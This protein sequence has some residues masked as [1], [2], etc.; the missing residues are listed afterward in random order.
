VVNEWLLDAH[1]LVLLREAVRTVDML[2]ELDAVVRRD[3]P[4]VDGQRGK[5][6]HPALVEARQ[7]KFALARLFAAL[8][9]PDGV[10]GDESRGRRQ[11]RVGARGTYK[12]GRQGLRPRTSG[13]TGRAHR[14]AGCP[15]VPDRAGVRGRL[16]PA[17][18]PAD[19]AP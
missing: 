2:D 12:V 17:H 11:R 14:S 1:E 16:G 13:D 10:P 7:L 4:V 9:L 18:G 6:A 8:R 3:G 15:P 19:V 5:R